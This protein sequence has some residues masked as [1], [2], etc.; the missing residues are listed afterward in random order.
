MKLKIICVGKLKEK[1]YADA[2][3]EFK[4]RLSKF[5]EIEIIE[6]ADERT[7]E[8]PNFSEIEK[9]KRSEGARI[10]EKISEGETLIALDIAGKEL[11]SEELAGKIQNYMLSGK[12]RLV[13]AIGGSN[14]LSDEV[15]NFAVFRLSFSKLT[16]PRRIFRLML[17]EQ[18]YRVFK[19]INNEPY[20]K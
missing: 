9:A 10:L 17:L 2:A 13:F 15:L 20:H 8:K 1:F 4:K 7:P 14:G 18:L 19:I 16:F 12:T 11:S 6:I 5:T 3:N